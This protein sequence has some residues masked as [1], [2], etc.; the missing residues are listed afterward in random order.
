MI[1]R[2]RDW[3][4]DSFATAILA[5]VFVIINWV[6]VLKSKGLLKTEEELYG[7][8]AFLMNVIP[9]IMGVIIIFHLVMF[10]IFYSIEKLYEA[11]KN[12]NV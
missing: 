10:F 3:T 2:L 9:M 11:Y 12:K 1:E 4:R 8:G 5:S 7:F 6:F